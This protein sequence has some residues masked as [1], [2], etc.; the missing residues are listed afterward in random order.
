MPLLKGLLKAMQMFTC[1]LGQS[2]FSG[3]VHQEDEGWVSCMQE[4]CIAQGI[5]PLLIFPINFCLLSFSLSNEASN[6]HWKIGLVS[7]LKDPACGTQCWKNEFHFSSSVLSHLFNYC[8]W[9]HWGVGYKLC[10]NK[11]KQLPALYGQH[12]LKRQRKEHRIKCNKHK[13]VKTSLMIHLIWSQKHFCSH[14]FSHQVLTCSE[15]KTANIYWNTNAW[16][17]T[18]KMPK[19]HEL[20]RIGKRTATALA[21]SL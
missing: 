17:L 13:H 5:A 9:K 8:Y 20:P 7:L 15:L 3:L 12:R 18:A 4:S 19:I 6:W 21:V 2:C 11:D 10:S 14:K 16:A 1:L